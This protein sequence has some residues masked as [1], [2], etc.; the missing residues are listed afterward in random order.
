[1]VKLR[2]QRFSLPSGLLL[3][4][5]GAAQAQSID[6]PGAVERALQSNPASHESAARTAGAE[7]GVAA[8][9]GAR[10]PRVSFDLNAARSNDPLSVFGF[11]LSQ[12]AATFRDFGLAD[13]AGT[14][15][16]DKASGDLNYPGYSVNYD[17]GLAFTV[18]LYSGQERA[19]LRGAEAQLEASRHR[20]ALTREQLTFDVLRTYQGVFA[21]RGIATAARQARVAAEHYLKT[22]QQQR[23]QD[24]ALTS[25]VLTAR[26]H[27]AGSRADEQAA[28]AAVADAEEAFRVAIGA[29][30]DGA[31][32][33]AA[34]VSL[35]KPAGTLAD[36]VA[37]ALRSNRALE[38]SRAQLDVHRAG[39]D[40]ARARAR[41]RV[42]L[43]LRRDWNSDV[44]AL[45]APSNTLLASVTWNLF[46]SGAQ[47]AAVRQAESAER[48]ATAALQAAEDRLR[49]DV[50]RRYRGL[51]TADAKVEAS[52]EARQEAEEAARLVGLRYEQGIAKL[53][54]V[55]AAQAR[56]D[57]ARAGA[58]QAR[59]DDLLARAGLRLI[60]NDLDPAAVG[61][62][63]AP[64][65]PANASTGEPQ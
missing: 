25:D 58:V 24:I 9:R 46:T 64:A 36:L 52:E 22:A 10:R 44:P 61:A 3:L 60:L 35:P 55:L 65:S 40:T 4:A 8:A 32:V 57:K 39:V 51:D 59:Y 21:A 11:R 56:L 41:P 49:L 53:N 27:L 43:T 38:A 63:P 31:L 19:R 28:R 34:P 23:A 20:E 62:A 54:D 12:R 47:Q 45:S 37:Q 17:T 29:E 18:P 13:Y 15:S 7:A 2:H 14:G 5:F 42:D 1:M 33:P 6:F 16:L 30:R 50:A 26:A 48:A